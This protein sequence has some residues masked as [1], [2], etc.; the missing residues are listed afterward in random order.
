MYNL[1]RIIDEVSGADIIC[2]QEVERFWPRS[3]NVDQVN[4]IANHF[5]DYYW[6]YGAG[7][8]IHIADSDP[9]HNHRRQFG[10]MILSRFPLCQVRNHLL[11]KYGSLDSLSIQRSALEA[12]LAFGPD[13]SPDV[14][15][16][17]SQCASISAL[18]I[19][20]I[21]LTHLSAETRL[22]Q[23]DRILDIHHNAVHEGYAI[24]GDVSGMDWESGIEQQV[25]SRDAILFG[26]LNCQPNSEE[27]NRLA[28]PV[29]DYGGHITSLDG[30]VDAWCYCGGD[31]MAGCTSDVNDIPAR[32]D[33]CF[34]SA[35]IRDRL[36]ACWVDENAMGSDHLPVWLELEI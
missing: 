19:Y 7:V 32:L 1:N 8:D 4:V 2:L 36:K 24:Q 20:S 16:D 13:V 17:L 5:E 23:I 22:P 35:S 3:G 28:G 33:Y 25:V 34:A 11:P 14:S 15:P 18:R 21:H 31:K 30:L 27:Y 9:R 12:T 10:N 6:S 29:S 26:D